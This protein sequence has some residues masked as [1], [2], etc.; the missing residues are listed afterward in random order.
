MSTKPYPFQEEGVYEIQKRKGR[1]LLAD[2]P[3]LGKTYQSLL[4]AWVYLPDDDR[5]IVVLCPATGKEG[6]KR[7][8][9]QHLGLRAEVLYG[10]KPSRGQIRPKGIFILNPDILG[11]AKGNADTWNKFLRQLK[12]KLVIADE[13]HAYTNPRAKRTKNLMALCKGVKHVIAMSGTPMTDRPAELWPIVNLLDPKLFPSQIRFLNRYCQPTFTPWGLKYRGATRLKELHKI[14]RNGP[15][16]RR[17]R[18]DVMKDLPPLIRTVVPVEIEDMKQYKSAESDIIGWLQKTHPKKANKARKAERLVR[19]SYL[20][21]LIAD[22][23]R[24]PVK[25]WINTF[26]QNS[27]EKLVVFGVRK[28]VVKGLHEDKDYARKSVLI[29]GGTA[30]HKRQGVIDSFLHDKSKRLFFG[31]IQAAGTVWNGKGVRDGAFIEF[32]W[33]PAEHTQAEARLYGMFRGKEGQSTFWNYIVAK[34]TIEEDMVRII[35]KKQKRLDSALDGKVTQDGL[36][37]ILDLM[38]KAMLHKR[39]K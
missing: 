4:W 1:A 14:L 5:P 30:Q 13:C 24:K 20:L 2:D 27:K 39:K 15:M 36:D 31:N 32:S 19:Y 11:P 16:I 8:A 12:P 26:L 17:L 35:H 7:Q 33:K 10:R 37:S 22:L 23:K 18:R 9:A 6:W 34:D 38:E 25:E 28:K 21:G 3:G 29:Y